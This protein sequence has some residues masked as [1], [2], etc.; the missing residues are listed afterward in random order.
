[1]LI[2]L[3]TLS[4]PLFALPDDNKQPL[5]IRAD[6]VDLNPNKHIGIYQGSVKIDQGSTHILSAKTTTVGN[7]KN[8]LVMATFEGNAS[9]QAHYWTKQDKDKPIFHAYADKIY[10]C[11]EKDQITLSG[12]ARVAQEQNQI[13]APTICY[14]TKTQQVTTPYHNEQ[15]RII[16]QSDKMHSLEPDL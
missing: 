8:K 1:M 3:F 15:T 6:S 11:P 4:L 13:T 2:I 12:N 14:N 10:Y 9:K 7:A 16:V 5:L